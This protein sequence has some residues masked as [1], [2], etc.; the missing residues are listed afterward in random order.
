MNGWRHSFIG[1]AVAGMLAAMA[2]PATA[3]EGQV[4]WA[5]RAGG[6]GSD[7]G[8]AIA[9]DADGFSTVTGGFEKTAT[10]GTGS[11]QVSLTAVGEE[12]AFVARYRPDGDVAWVQQIAMS[13]EGTGFG[14]AVDPVG[15]A[16][17]TGSFDGTATFGSGAQQVTLTSGGLLRVDAFI[18]RYGPDGRLL[19]AVQ[20]GGGSVTVGRDVAVDASGAATVTGFFSGTAT[21]GTGPDQTTLNSAGME[22]A[23]VARYRADGSLDWA[24]QIGGPDIDSGSG[25]SMGPN[26]S[27]VVTGN[28]SG[29]AAFGSTTLISAGS[30]DAFVARY[31]PD[32]SL[33]WA[34]GAGGTDYDAGMDVA[35]DS[36]GAATVIGDFNGTAVFGSA[37]EQVTVNG[38][39]DIFIARYGADGALDWAQQAGGPKSEGARG[40]AVD[41]SG[42]ATLT[43]YIEGAATFGTGSDQVTLI[44]E[45]EQDPFLARYDASG[46]LVWA[47]SAPTSELG[48]G[49][50]VAVD[51]TGAA[52]V[53]GFFR[54]TVSFRPSLTLSS[55][56][57]GDVFV[58]RY[59]TVPELTAIEVAGPPSATTG[60]QVCVTATATDQ[61]GRPMPGVNLSLQITGAN[62]GS[63][64]GA[65]GPQGTWLYCYTGTRTGTDTVTV[66][67]DTGV[68]RA[69][70][71]A[72]TTVQ[73]SAQPKKTLPILVQQAKKSPVSLGP[74]G[75]AVVVQQISTNSK[76]RI[77]VR[78]SCRPT[79]PTAAGEVRF[80]DT[81]VTRSGKVT[82]ISTGYGAA[83]ITVRAKATPRPAHRDTWKANT[84]I[85]SWKIR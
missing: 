53:T 12:D 23:F 36:S 71:T 66:N 81:K 78:A 43:G 33:E 6:S 79:K 19:W 22:D 82:V 16:T 8:Q 57:R 37:G 59:D 69:R 17:V 7:E 85:R 10:F 3:G 9:V 58:A 50:G 2:A 74:D 51:A 14:V 26:G 32:G 64:S 42:L 25:V 40:V 63:A 39:N 49:R 83:R 38:S 67:G 24:R 21:F 4:L 27:A 41:R 45:G 46:T 62:P 35:V 30:A 77:A 84:W 13:Y 52:F 20:A 60:S 76:G 72:S 55:V 15:T 75:R 68:Q 34:Q 5:Q 18:A 54:G 70:I 31:L 1:V 47:E 44:G 73:W 48:T 56:G 61:R 11:S 65:T 80:C 29:T 28:F